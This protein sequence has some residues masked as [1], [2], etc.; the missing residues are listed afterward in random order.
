L[1]DISAGNFIDGTAIGFR[2]PGIGLSEAEFDQISSR[3]LTKSVSAGKF[4]TKED[5][6]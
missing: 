3:K 4:L 2:K 6:E 1:S 5:F